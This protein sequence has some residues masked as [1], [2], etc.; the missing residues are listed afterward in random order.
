MDIH[1][2]R[3]LSD[4]VQLAYVYRV[5]TYLAR[6][7]DDFHRAALLYQMPEPFFVELAYD[8]EANK[9]EFCFPFEAG[10]EDDRLPDYAMFVKLPDWMEGD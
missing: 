8:T 10:S 2:F 3:L 9:V 5:G 7:W 6:R 1:A 4:E